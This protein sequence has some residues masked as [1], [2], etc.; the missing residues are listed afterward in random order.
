MIS[1]QLP[2]CCPLL[3]LSRAGDIPSGGAAVVT[4]TP[5]QYHRNNT[6]AA[7]AERASNICVMGGFSQHM[8]HVV[9]IIRVICTV[10][11]LLLSNIVKLFQIH[12]CIFRIIVK[13]RQGSG[14][15]GQGMA[16]KAKGLKV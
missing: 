14:K 4:T 15:D 1:E 3:R 10:L 11:L 13:L 8:D 5:P 12:Y 6:P 16:L 9:I 7:T 2:P